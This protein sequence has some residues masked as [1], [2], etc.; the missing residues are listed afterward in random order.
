MSSALG[1]EM[2]RKE[3]IVKYEQVAL[4]VASHQCR[5]LACRSHREAG[6]LGVGLVA[7]VMAFCSHRHVHPW[8]ISVQGGG[9]TLRTSRGLAA[10]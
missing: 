1:S 9:S 3:Q 5:L 6:E 10:G 4:D 2:P 8:L 7:H